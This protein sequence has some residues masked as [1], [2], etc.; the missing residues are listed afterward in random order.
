MLLLNDSTG[1]LARYLLHRAQ[2]QW[3]PP[4]SSFHLVITAARTARAWEPSG[5]KAPGRELW[6]PSSARGKTP[7]R[8][9]ATTTAWISIAASPW[10]VFKASPSEAAPSCSSRWHA[11]G[12]SN[13]PV[14]T[15]APKARQAFSPVSS[16]G[17]WWRPRSQRRPLEREPLPLRA[18]LE[19]AHRP[20]HHRT[21]LY[22]ATT[23]D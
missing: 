23:S 15:I 21:A 7:H 9:A 16:G 18:P 17:T 14:R 19:E 11:V 3:P 22:S 1:Y 20:S 10:A 8:R 2:P 6:P 4:S 13:Q 12:P 5:R